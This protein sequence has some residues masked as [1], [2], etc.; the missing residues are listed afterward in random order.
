MSVKEFLGDANKL[1]KAFE[2]TK[3]VL[4]NEYENQSLKGSMDCIQTILKRDV[5]LGNR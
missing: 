1:D 5:T 2:S 4:V 3:Q